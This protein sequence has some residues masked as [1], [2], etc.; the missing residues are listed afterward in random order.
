[1]KLK[2]KPTLNDLEEMLG[3]KER[4]LFYLTW[5][6]EGRNAKKAYLKL[7][8]DVTE[9][10]AE[11]LGSK[12]LS[13]IDMKAVAMAYG[14]NH[15]KYFD[16][17]RKAMDA[18]KW[19]DFT[20]EREPDYKTIKPYHDKLGK[21]LEIEKEETPQINIGIQNVIDEQRKKYEV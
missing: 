12:M 2:K 19:N 8:P 13:N 17:L 5:L 11:V 18:T 10:S 1:M 4:V 9:H 7:H 14:L 21:L 15:D 20:G 16:V 6:E 3:S